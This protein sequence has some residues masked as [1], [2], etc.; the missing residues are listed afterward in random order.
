MS[1]LQAQKKQEPAAELQ[2]D[3]CKP[4]E[5]ASGPSSQPDL[6]QVARSEG[7]YLAHAD[8][9]ADM[10][11]QQ[12]PAGQADSCRQPDDMQFKASA[13]TTTSSSQLNDEATENEAETECV[14]CWAAAP[15]AL[16]QPCG[17]LCTCAWCAKAYFSGSSAECPICR[18]K[19]TAVIQLALSP[20]GRAC[21][22]AHSHCMRHVKEKEKEKEKKKKKKKKKKNKENRQFCFLCEND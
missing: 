18:T 11:Q 19:I 8:D 22:Q 14:V 13:C 7:T 3:V 12:P 21:I 20:C 9:L 5:L 17:H 16:F 15:G 2:Q 4:V 1:L 6:H 10:Q